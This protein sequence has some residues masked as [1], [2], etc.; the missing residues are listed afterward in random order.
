ML[1]HVRLQLSSRKRFSAPPENFNSGLPLSV[2]VTSRS[3]QSISSVQPVPRAFNPA[4]FAARRAASRWYGSAAAL[5]YVISAGVKMR[6]RKE[7]FLLSASL[8]NSCISTMSTP[9][10]AIM[11]TRITGT[12]PSVNVLLENG[13]VRIEWFDQPLM[14]V[15]DQCMASHQVRAQI[16]Y[17]GILRSQIEISYTRIRLTVGNSRSMK[18]VRQSVGECAKSAPEPSTESMREP[19]QFRL[20]SRCK[21]TR[22]LSHVLANKRKQPETKVLGPLCPS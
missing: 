3:C 2:L 4:S 6:F 1:S 13:G 22:G 15:Q 20:H 5:A 10:P 7:S 12:I 11:H 9:I 19:L 14:P 21:R 16:E 8:L 18:T 17:G